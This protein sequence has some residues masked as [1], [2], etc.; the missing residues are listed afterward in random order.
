M[1]KLAKTYNP[2]KVENRIY[3]LWQKSGFF[4]PDKLP[5]KRKRVFT[6]VIPPP[7]ITG[8]LHLGHALNA[9]IQDILIRQKRMAGFKTL[10]LPGIDH[11][12]IATQ[13]VVEKELKKEGKTRFDLGREKFIKRIW[14]WKRKYGNVI[15]DQLKKLGASCDWSRTRFTLDPDYIKAVETA[16]SYY[17]KKGWIYRGKKVVNWCPRCQTSLSDLELEYREEKGKLWYIRYPLKKQKT[18]NKKQFITVATTRPETMLGDAAVAVN[19]NDKRYKDL[20]GE[21]AILPLVNKKIPI[22]A[23]PLVDPRFGTG[24]VKITP[25]HDLKDFEI[26]QRHKL[27]LVQVINEEGEIAKE[28][29]SSYQGL[30]ILAA[31]Q[32]VVEDLRKLNFLEKTED[33]TYQIPQCY[34]C[35]TTIELIPSEQWFLKMNQLAK[36]AQKP[37]KESKIEFYPKSFEKSY[38]NWLKNIKDWCISRQIWWG[39]KIPLEGEKDVLDTWFSSAL[40]PF[41]TLG[42]PP[43]SKRRAKKSDLDKFY[44]T[45]ILSTARDIINLWVARM[46]FSALELTKKIPFR[47]IYIHPTVLTLAGK[48]MSKSLGIGV[49]PLQLIEKYGAD[50]TRFGIAWQLTGAQDVRFSED[51]IVAGKKFC[52]KIWNATRF[53]LANKPTRIN[54][55]FGSLRSQRG[56]TR[57]KNLTLADKRILKALNETIKSINKNLENFR[58]GQALHKLYHFF[59]HDFC[60]VYIEES[61]KQLQ[62]TNYKLPARGEARQ[63]RQTTRVLIC[64]LLTSLRLLHPFIPFITEEIYQ[65]LPL[66][67]KK[68]CLMIEDW[69]Q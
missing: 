44:P 40:W 9:V 62:T 7:N 5:G 60:D 13:N 4:N 20:V 10:W 28:A 12:G 47:K 18:R 22:I 17:H 42:W 11:A 21:K 32:K 1:E 41:A 61:K 30:S 46:I 19:P 51:H 63:R 26:S 8:E 34:R 33:Y 25:A 57:I 36:L 15:L 64:V 3:Q 66:E 31:R 55:D 65:K 37:V 38:F 43:A 52:N 2:K 53:V 49:D 24:A 39:H 16:F 50:A 14:K 23:D 59:W 54:A 45:D 68:K 48:R 58:F 56:F 29:P 6:I 27:T 69:P 67:N 35:K